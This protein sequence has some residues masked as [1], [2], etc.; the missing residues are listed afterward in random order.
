MGLTVSAMKQQ[1]EM[2]K[3]ATTNGHLPG[4][5]F[6]HGV[7]F[8]NKCNAI[9]TYIQRKEGITSFAGLHKGKCL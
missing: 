2:L 4:H 6:N 8:C 1:D 7:T 3:V 5:Y 9:L